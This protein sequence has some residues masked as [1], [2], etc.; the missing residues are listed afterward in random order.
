MSHRS[1]KGLG[2]KS[3]QPTGGVTPEETTPC[4]RSKREP[5]LKTHRK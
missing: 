1:I 2:S 3:E 5:L 4:G